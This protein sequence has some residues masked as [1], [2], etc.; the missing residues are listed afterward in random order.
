MA[1]E[2]VHQ[3]RKTAGSECMQALPVR[4]VPA[5]QICAGSREVLWVLQQQVWDSPRGDCA[6][7][8]AAPVET[9]DWAMPE[10][11]PLRRLGMWRC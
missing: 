5:R 7:V 4:R 8:E 10:L 6:D 3:P 2:R 9:A 11:P 1:R